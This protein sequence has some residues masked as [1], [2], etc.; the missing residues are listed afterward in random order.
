MGTTSQTA[1]TDIANLLRL[2]FEGFKR[3]NVFYVVPRGYDELPAWNGKDLD[4]LVARADLGEA[5][6]I[7]RRACDAAGFAVISSS[8]DDG[9]GIELR[10]LSINTGG[11]EVLS[12]DIRYL[13]AIELTGKN[14]LR[15]KIPVAQ[16]RR[17]EL[18]Q[19]ACSFY[20]LD[21]IDEFLATLRQFLLKRLAGNA[22]K[23]EFY[24]DRLQ[25]LLR[26]PAAAQ[27]L[28]SQRL[29]A[30]EV[31]RMLANGVPQVQA[32]LC[33]LADVR[34]G[35]SGPLG[36]LQA[37]A[38]IASRRWRPALAWPGP[39]VY[40]SGPDGA[41]KTTVTEHLEE[42]LSASGIEHRR[43]YSMKILLRGLTRRLAWL[44]MRA[45]AP[46]GLQSQ[47][48][49][50]ALPVLRGEDTRD[51]DDGTSYWRFRKA[52]ALV[53]GIADIWIG[54]LICLWYRRNG[55]I[56]L[57]ETSPYDIF[58]KYHMPEISWAERLLGPLVPKPSV[59]FLLVADPAKI[60]IRK[61][62]LSEEELADYYDRF[63]RIL[64]RS[65]A[66]RSYVHV[67]TD[68]DLRQTH[69]SIAR[70]VFRVRRI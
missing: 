49:R 24:K 59:G 56:A 29:G 15:R 43:V 40:F 39:I 54:Y 12:F 26:Q 10:A 36:R 69:T 65:R 45:R 61:G 22:E 19:N 27:W 6:G 3:E 53:V 58:V 51:R 47:D 28:A 38:R 42:L 55:R 70:E 20:T 1:E 18:S 7:I 5:I 16:L 17:R 57:V 52:V 62:E 34:W 9:H 30:A 32:A 48:E 25:T 31:N 8:P 4:L 60:F 37:S 13:L 21:A 14:V 68:G 11:A 41:G 67:R 23:A 46:A 63:D 33:A 66:E 35:E 50:N 64:Q 44:K 2:V